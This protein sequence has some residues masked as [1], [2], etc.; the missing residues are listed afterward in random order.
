MPETCDYEQRTKRSVPS[1]TIP[2]EAIAEICHEAN[3]A[4]CHVLGDDSQPSWADAPDW[5]KESAIDGVKRHVEKSQMLVS[6]DWSHNQW[7]ER[8]LKEGWTYGPVKD[9]ENKQHPCLLPYEFLP[10][11]EKRKD[12]LFRRIVQSFIDYN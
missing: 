8:K 1:T 6:C 2:V 9:A 12:E 11:S 3:R 10:E 5:Q 7:M 4:Y